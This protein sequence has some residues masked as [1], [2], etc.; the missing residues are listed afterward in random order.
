MPETVSQSASPGVQLIALCA[1]SLNE[2]VL[3]APFIKTDAFR[4]VVESVPS[5]VTLHCITR[6]RPDEIAVGV[7]DLDVWP[8]LRDRGRSSLRLCANLHAKYYRAD[9]NC[10]VGSANITAAALG[11]AAQPNLELLV[12][13]SHEAQALTGFESQVFAVSAE[14]DDSIYEQMVDIVQA[15]STQVQRLSCQLE[16]VGSIDASEENGLISQPDPFW[17]PSLRNP[18]ELFLAYAGR[19]DRLSA[20]SQEAGTDDL[21]A[22]VVTPGLP[23]EAFEA[24]VGGLM[25]QQP[26]IRKIDVLVAT[27]QRFG[28]VRDTIAAMVP[29]GR[30]A[31]F[32]ADRAWQTL[33]RWLR[34]FLPDRYG[35]SVPRHS[36]VFY[37]MRMGSNDELRRR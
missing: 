11:W 18:E 4:R 24:Y 17:L 20:A 2:V 22:L 5:E 21:A 9:T 27:P 6:W 29:E 34:H 10:L 37:R 25:L 13:V 32:D 7:S 35:L 31:G 19:I 36:E 3:C 26:A 23:R 30:A 16:P 8:F 12:P 33:M 1:Q 15:I 28:A 14:V